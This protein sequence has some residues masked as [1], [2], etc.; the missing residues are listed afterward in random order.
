MSKLPKWG[1]SSFQVKLPNTDGY[2]NLGV[3][4]PDASLT[5]GVIPRKP[6][7]NCEV[8]HSHD[9]EA[10]LHPSPEVQKKMDEIRKLYMDDLS[11]RIREFNTRVEEFVMDALRTRV[12][13]LLKGEITPGKIRYRNIKLLYADGGMAFVGILQR[14]KILYSVDGNTYDIIDYRRIDKDSIQANFVKRQ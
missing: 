1:E 6:I 10:L 11:Q 2:V 5:R 7:F 8:R 13:P 4:K 3:V 9:F 14:K 12:K